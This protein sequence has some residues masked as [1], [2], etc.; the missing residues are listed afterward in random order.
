MTQLIVALDNISHSQ[1]KERGVLSILAEAREAGMIW[2]VK[3]NDMLYSGDSS[4][5]IHSLSPSSQR[6]ARRA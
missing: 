6:H 5:I 3:I 4:V 1:A 2:G